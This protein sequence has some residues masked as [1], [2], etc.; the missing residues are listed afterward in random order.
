MEEAFKEKAIIYISIS[1]NLKLIL[2]KKSHLQ[3]PRTRAFEHINK[4]THI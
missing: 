1:I 4:V 3:Y 2:K